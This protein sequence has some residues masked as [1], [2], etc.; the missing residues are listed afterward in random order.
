MQV[1]YRPSLCLAPPPPLPP[2]A[3]VHR[4]SSLFVA[5][6]PEL[7][8]GRLLPWASGHSRWKTSVT[9]CV[10]DRPAIGGRM[11]F[12]VAPYSK[13]YSWGGRSTA[14]DRAFPAAVVVSAI[15]GGVVAESVLVTMHALRRIPPHRTSLHCTALHCPS[16]H[17]ADASASSRP[18]AA[19]SLSCAQQRALCPPSGLAPTWRRK[20]VRWSMMWRWGVNLLEETVV[21]GRVRAAAALRT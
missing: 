7:S 4:H 16:P 2:R 11:R 13:I 12:P 15:G 1:G 10:V 19:L 17:H 18:T 8:T 9:A 6:T 20:S 21:W 14:V 5:R 3:R